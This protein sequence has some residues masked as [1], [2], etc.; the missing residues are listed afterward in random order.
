MLIKEILFKQMSILSAILGLILGVLTII[1]FVRNFSFF[2]L[3]L[4]AA[5]IIMVYMKKMQMMGILDIKQGAVY[6]AIIG[7]ISFWGF[8]I[9]FFPL[10]M[11]I[12]FINKYSFYS[13]ISDP[14]LHGGLFVLIMLLFFVALL[15]SLTNSFSGMVTMYIYN[16]IEPKPEEAQTDIDIKE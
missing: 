11:I 12:S 7:F 13:V 10:A 3:F 14:I 6:G 8:S 1:P 4:F 9:S 15:F 16:Q 2:A 5:P